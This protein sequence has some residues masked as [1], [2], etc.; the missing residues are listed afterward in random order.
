[1]TTATSMFSTVA[2][3]ARYRPSS[4]DRS[5]PLPTTSAWAVRRCGPVQAARLI[6]ASSLARRAS[7]SAGSW[8]ASRRAARSSCSTARRAV[9]SSSTAATGGSTLSSETARVSS[10]QVNNLVGGALRSSSRSPSSPSSSP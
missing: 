5:S 3:S 4:S 6:L 2:Y 8:S 7:S 1:M 10:I 9:S